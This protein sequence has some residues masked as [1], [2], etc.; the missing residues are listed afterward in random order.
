MLNRRKLRL[1]VNESKLCSI[2]VANDYHSELNG[3][4]HS[5]LKFIIMTLSKVESCYRVS[6][7]MDTD[8][9]GMKDSLQITWPYFSNNF[10]L[11]KKEKFPIIFGSRLLLLFQVFINLWDY[12][13]SVFPLF[14]K[15]KAQV[16]HWINKLKFKSPT[17]S[18]FLQQLFEFLKR[19]EHVLTLLLLQHKVRWWWHLILPNNSV[20]CIEVPWS[21]G[22]GFTVWSMEQPR[23]GSWVYSALH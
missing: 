17:F 16:H 6:Y 4:R 3:I 20:A 5:F 10:F 22:T 14:T 2:Y 15:E 1:Q 13:L 11:K 18:A 23:G 7:C 9:P 21:K 12:H 19:G 8:M